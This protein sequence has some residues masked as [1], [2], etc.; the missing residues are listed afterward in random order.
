MIVIGSRLCLLVAG[1][2]LAGVS[3][4]VDSVFAQAPGT[5]ITAPGQ[6][7]SEKLSRSV[8]RNIFLTRESRA[9]NGAASLTRYIGRRM[10]LERRFVSR[11]R[12]RRP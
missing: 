6:N 3:L 2:S 12:P 9:P 8:C 1:M 7:L 4:A 11:S 5:Q 10:R